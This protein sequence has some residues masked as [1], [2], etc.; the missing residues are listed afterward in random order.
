MLS[1]LYPT[2][3]RG[4]SRRTTTFSKK[5]KL[6]PNTSQHTADKMVVHQS[7]GSI[8]SETQKRNMA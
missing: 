6:L 7:T 1:W 4:F 8:R 2:E 5:P 3:N